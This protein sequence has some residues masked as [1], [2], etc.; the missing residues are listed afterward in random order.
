MG[1][2]IS[3]SSLPR[4]SNSFRILN[5]ARML[6]YAGWTC[7]VC[8]KG[9]GV[10]LTGD[11]NS[12]GVLCHCN[13]RIADQAVKS[14]SADVQHLIGIQHNIALLFQVWICF[15]IAAVNIY[16]TVF[17]ISVDLHFIRH[18]RIQTEDFAFT[19]AENLSIGVAVNQ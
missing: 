19:V 11:R 5:H 2:C 13:R 6:Q 1:I 4:I 15:I 12:D 9:S 14:K 3:I 18:Q 8:K 7:Y 16:Q 10:I 17:L